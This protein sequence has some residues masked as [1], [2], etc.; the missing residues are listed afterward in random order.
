MRDLT[1]NKKVQENDNTGLTESRKTQS[2][3]Q[4][5]IVHIEDITSSKIQIIDN[6]EK[7][8]QVMEQMKSLDFNDSFSASKDSQ[9]D[10]LIKTVLQP[11]KTFDFKKK[12]NLFSKH[13]CHELNFFLFK[14]DK[15]FYDKA[16]KFLIQNKLEKTFVDQY[17]LGS[18][19]AGS[20][21]DYAK[22]IL[23][24]VESAVKVE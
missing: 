3:K 2:L 9:F 4:G 5:D 15:E 13:T 20:D 16:V 1:V 24:H 11:W 23:S 8:H 7:V 12:C 18:E 21:N 10:S 17:M 6:M 19:L 22:Y 14:K